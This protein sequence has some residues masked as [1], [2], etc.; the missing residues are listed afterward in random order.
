MCRKQQAGFTLIEIAIV[1][2]VVGLLLGGMLKGQQLI[3]SAKLKNL[4]NDF[5]G[6]Q[7]AIYAYQ[8]RFRATPGD[9]AAASTHVNGATNPT[10]PAGVIGNARINGKFDSANGTDE[11]FLIWQHLRLA[12]LLTG[13]PD[14]GAADY[15]PRNADGG[16]IGVTSEPV[17]TAPTTPYPGNFFIC[18]RSIQG[19]YVRQMD[20][21]FDD[22]DTQTGTIRAIANDVSA[23]PDASVVRPGDDATLYTVC[24]AL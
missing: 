4:T 11:S 3:N 22:G 2:V 17:L 15:I 14:T 19:R 12:G 20:T 5:R 23:Q 6:V 21:S 16:I 1:L 18:S 7:I 13:S 8:D 9:D 10:T 24:S